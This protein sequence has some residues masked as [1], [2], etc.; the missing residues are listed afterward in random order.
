MPSA[1]MPV[2]RSQRVRARWAWLPWA[3]ASSR[4]RKLLPLLWAL[5]KGIMAG[6]EFT[7]NTRV[8][9]DTIEVRNTPVTADQLAP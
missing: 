3:S 5:R 1:P 9:R 4:R 7:C 2:E 6:F 8:V